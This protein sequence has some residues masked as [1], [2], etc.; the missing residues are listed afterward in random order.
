MFRP[1]NRENE[2]TDLKTLAICLFKSQI[3]G[4]YLK[5]QQRYDFRKKQNCCAAQKREIL[6]S[7]NLAFILVFIGI[8][9]V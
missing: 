8:K 7:R 2:T 6:K 4:R 1:R 3:S 9:Y 5:K